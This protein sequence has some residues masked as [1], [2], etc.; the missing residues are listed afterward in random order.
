MNSIN[1]SRINPVFEALCYLTRRV[2]GHTISCASEEL[3]KQH[4][5][6]TDEIDRLSQPYIAIERELDKLIDISDPEYERFFRCFRWP[7][8]DGVSFNNIASMYCATVL[9]D[10]APLN[11]NDLKE[12][13][14]GLIETDRMFLII[15]HQASNR[16]NYI[17]AFSDRMDFLRRIDQLDL[18]PECK[19]TCIECYLH[20]EENIEA[21][22]PILQN[23]A[24]TFERVVCSADVL[25]STKLSDAEPDKLKDIITQNTG[26]SFDLETDTVVFGSYMLYTVIVY[27]ILKHAPDELRMENWNQTTLY[28]GTSWFEAHTM[29]DGE[30]GP[31]CESV[32]EALR[33]I[34]D[35]SRL[36]ILRILS[37]QSVYAKELCEMLNLSPSAVS[38]HVSKL[39]EAGIVSCRIDSTRTYY[40]INSDKTTELIQNVNSI[41][42]GN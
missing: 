13:L 16:I 32:A 35:P 18:T 11:V 37:R 17:N 28:V 29:E 1:P 7:D 9:L 8:S 23:A 31:S 33:T 3:K 24:E 25:P 30:N 4:P 27:S 6:M 10:E 38:K 20:Y 19:W 34:A 42:A 36:K 26:I 14:L 5:A 21:L 39:V 12:R 40:S 2:N 22:M 15:H 41:I